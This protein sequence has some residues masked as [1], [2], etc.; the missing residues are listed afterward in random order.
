MAKTDF[1]SVDQYIAA[2]PETVQSVLGRVRST[3]R[4]A[5]PGAEEAISYKI[6]VYKLHGAPV[7][8]FAGWKKHY[9]LYPATEGVVA[10]FK[11]SLASYEISKGTI[12]FPLGEP[13]PVELIE[14]IAKLRAREVA[15]RETAKTAA[16]K[17]R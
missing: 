12:R 13:V 17:E 11:D 5:M 9:S 4:E 15:E 1:N 7:I 14:G 2:Q 16:P 6:P 3:I 10:A 8:Y